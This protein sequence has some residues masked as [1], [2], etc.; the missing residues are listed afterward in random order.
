V[1]DILGFTVGASQRGA[2]A[3][4]VEFIVDDEAA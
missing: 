1:G 4:Q 2:F 3:E